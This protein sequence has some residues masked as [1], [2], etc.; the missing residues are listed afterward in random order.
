[1]V[2]KSYKNHEGKG[3]GPLEIKEY[4]RIAASCVQNL[5]VLVG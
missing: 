2:Q 4:G 3:D 1:M 5:L